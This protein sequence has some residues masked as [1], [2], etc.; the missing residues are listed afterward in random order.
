[1]SIPLLVVETNAILD[2]LIWPHSLNGDY[3]VKKAYEILTQTTNDSR[4]PTNITPPFW[5]QLW[6]IKLPQKILTPL[7]GNNYGKSNFLRKSSHLHGKYC[8][9]PSLSKQSLT[10]EE[11]T[12][13]W[14]AYCATMPLKPRSSL[15]TL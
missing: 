12:V 1:L 8:I 15:P 7:F 6:K 3:Q 4:P 9:M 13:L 14:P 11:Y 10:E 2:K 5:K